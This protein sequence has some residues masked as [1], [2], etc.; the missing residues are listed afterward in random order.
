MFNSQVKAVIDRV[1]RLRTQV[2]DHWQI[3]RDE[4][5]VLAQL[6]RVGR[7]GSLVEVGV[8]YGFSTLHLTAAAKA[9]GGHVHAI[10][11]DP[12]KIDAATANLTDAGLID[13]VTLY[14]GDA[15]DVLQTIKP[16]EPFDFAFVD[17]DKPQSLAYL[18]ALWDKLADRAVI[19]TDNI[20]THP[21]ELTDY[22]GDL[23]ARPGVTSCGV[24]V[25]NGFE[26][27]IVER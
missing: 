26:L 10:D 8:S 16:A 4:A 22:I 11:I 17:A 6:V 15:R 13:H 19:I 1:D 2:D 21:E 27:T 20:S 14:L 12:K 7:C 5:R 9:N 23:R 24:P 25:G 3:P 18:D